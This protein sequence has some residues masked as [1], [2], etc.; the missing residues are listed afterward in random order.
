[1][2]GCVRGDLESQESRRHRGDGQ[3]EEAEHVEYIE[4]MACGVIFAN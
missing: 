2:K 1:M 4:A 3:E